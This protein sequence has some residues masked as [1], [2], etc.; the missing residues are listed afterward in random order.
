[1]DLCYNA[2]M[3]K[4]DTNAWNVIGHAPVLD[5]FDRV[6]EKDRIGH[7]YILSG[8]TSVG[9]MT[10]AW[11]FAARL[12]KTHP[13]QLKAHP[14]LV[15][16]QREINKKTKKLREQ[17]SVEQIQEARARFQQ[18]AM[19]GGYKVLIIE[20]A[21]Q[22][23]DAAANALLK[24][25][26]EPR[27]KACILLTTTDETKLLPTIRSRSQTLHVRPVPREEICDGIVDR[28]GSREEAHELA[29]LA[30]GSPGVAIALTDDPEMRTMIDARYGVTQA[31]LDAS[32]AKRILAARNTLPAYDEDH[33]KTRTELLARLDAL[34]VQARD[35]LLAQMN[36]TDLA[37]REVP[38]DMSSKQL[39]GLLHELPTL[40]VQLEQHLN[41]K[42]ALIQLMTRL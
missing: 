12:L 22:L 37:A 41:P 17:L 40:R 31:C 4:T 24:T 16:V 26:E 9:K 36:C 27:G 15:V 21:Q 32:A 11:R 33:V 23:S 2:F 28:V 25:L 14:D 38:S 42:L 35:A 30:A 19:H 10:I 29:G 7:A 1:M 34:E 5:Y 20:G 13:G 39:T 6:V 8:P 3:P 18:T